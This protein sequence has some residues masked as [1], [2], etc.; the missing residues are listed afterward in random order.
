M[1]AAHAHP[2]R[3][4]DGRALPTSLLAAHLAFETLCAANSAEY[5]RV[6]LANKITD[7]D[8]NANYL[9]DGE[10]PS[11][12]LRST[13]V[14]ASVPTPAARFPSLVPR[15]A[16]SNIAAATS[17]NGNAPTRF[18][19]GAPP[20]IAEPVNFFQSRTLP[21]LSLYELARALHRS[22]Q[23]GDDALLAGLVLAWRYCAATSTKP[24][25]H[26]MHR[27]YVGCL[28]L[29]I[30]THSDE[31]FRNSTFARFA[32]IGTLELN[33]IESVIV[34]GLDWRLLVQ[35]GDL[36]RL[37]SFPASLSRDSTMRF[38]IAAPSP[39]PSSAE[40]SDDDESVEMPAACVA[41]I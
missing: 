30:K 23:C 32:G 14:H 25:L 31:F 15:A 26:S 10:A 4:A 29:A 16:S 3:D 27:L 18:A 33:R 35:P 24:T 41:T 8:S 36:V 39:S 20:P 19:P 9:A 40:V 22:T 13:D 5:A 21:G 7:F 17:P 37:Y 28:H 11:P 34:A 38:V 2:R 12:G 1:N 6:V